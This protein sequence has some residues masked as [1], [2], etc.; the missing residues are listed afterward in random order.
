MYYKQR[1]GLYKAK[2]SK[3][4]ALMS[5]ESRYEYEN[6]IRDADVTLYQFDQRKQN[7]DL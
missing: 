6:A 2:D 4:A 7:T 3:R 5:Q 1:T